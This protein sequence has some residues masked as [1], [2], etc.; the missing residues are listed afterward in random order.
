MATFTF[1]QHLSR[2][3]FLRAAGLTMA[4]PWLESM[5][6]ALARSATPTAP[7]RFVAVSN[8]L[9]F[10]AP[11]L[12][13]EK[14]GRDYELT[15]Y[16]QSIGDL[17]NQFT[18]VSGVSHPGVSRG[19]L[20]D[21]CILTARPNLSGSNFRNGISLD[22][23]MVKHLGNQT[24]FPSLP[25]AVGADMGTSFTEL[26]AMISPETS[27]QRLFGRLF[28]KDTPQARQENL[29]RLREGRSVMDVV[30]AEAKA[31][32]RRVGS[33][34][35]DKLDAFFTSVR[36][37][38]EKLAADQAWADRPKPQ[39]AAEPPKPVLNRAD[40][41]AVQKQM[42]ELAA[43]ALQTD[44]TRFIT[45][46]IGGGGG[47]V[48]LEG[49]EEGYHNLSHHGLDPNKISQL[50]IVEEAQMSAWGDFLRRLQTVQ[51][52]NSTLLDQTMA[53]LTS[54]LGNA[55]AHDTKNMPVVFA[56]GGFRHGQHL[57]FDRKDNYPLPNLFVSMLQRLDL[58]YDKFVTGTA[59]MNGLEM[60]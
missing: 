23:L 32:Q 10:H 14:P 11:F 26:G 7:R 53:L 50:S 43:L 27:P 58:P 8:E 49:V 54:N 28:G 45:L 35:R 31:M 3:T 52:G 15:R 22:Q 17:R 1:Q 9:G 39:V 40:V 51:E 29:D 25:L 47:K 37:L 19:H 4:L 5:V 42:Y 34:D 57:A 13:P 2:R 59:P 36:E 6:P 18:V 44:S 55:S 20:S 56:G 12:F 30:G 38:E 41:I 60:V 16:L 46:H 21:V 33:G 24:R 48:P